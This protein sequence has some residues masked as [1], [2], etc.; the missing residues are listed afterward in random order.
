MVTSRNS[1]LLGTVFD[2][3]VTYLLI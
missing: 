3:V 1:N 2:C